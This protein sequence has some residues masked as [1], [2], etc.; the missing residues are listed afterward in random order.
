MCQQV[1]FVGCAKVNEW[2]TGGVVAL[3]QITLDS[4]PVIFNDSCRSKRES[5]DSDHVHVGVCYHSYFKDRRAL[6]HRLQ[7]RCGLSL[8][9]L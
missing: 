3:C 9:V 1:K 7:Q 8:S 5:E 4:M 2:R 6:L